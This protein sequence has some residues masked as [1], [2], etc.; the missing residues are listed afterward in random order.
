ME[1]LMRML[2]ILLTCILISCNEVQVS[3]PVGSEEDKTQIKRQNEE[4]KTLEEEVQSFKQEEDQRAAD[5]LLR[6]QQEKEDARIGDTSWLP[7]NRYVF[8]SLNADCNPS[9]AIIFTRLSN[10]IGICAGALIDAETII[11][12]ASCLPQDVIDQV[13]DCKDNVVIK[14]PSRQ[15]LG[16][17]EG[18]KEYDSKQV[19][20]K[21]ILSYSKNE[22][23]SSNF[24]QDTSTNLTADFAIIKLAKPVSRPPFFS[25]PSLTIKA[26]EHYNVIDISRNEGRTGWITVANQKCST[27]KNDSVENGKSNNLLPLDCGG[28]SLAG[29]PIFQTDNSNNSS[30]FGLLQNYSFKKS[31]SF[32]SMGINSGE[33]TFYNL[34]VGLSL[35]CVLDPGSCYNLSL[36]NFVNATVVDDKERQLQIWLGKHDGKAK[37]LVEEPLQDLFEWEFVERVQDSGRLE[38]LFY[39]PGQKNRLGSTID[40]QR[41][42]LGMA[43]PKCFKEMSN[44][45]WLY[46]LGRLKNLTYR[47]NMNV[48]LS[49][50]D[51]KLF[52]YTFDGKYRVSLSTYR[53]KEFKY[54]GY[55]DDKDRE[56]FDL[57]I[58]S[59]NEQAKKEDVMFLTFVDLVP[60]RRMADRIIFTVKVPRCVKDPI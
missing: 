44:I 13:V 2:L 45:H 27:L 24:T 60:N 42:D 48:D 12:S 33:K 38:R 25:H 11:T 49:T 9:S 10:D 58:E 29:S 46:H 36:K 7:Y 23:L 37:Y 43:L 14:F 54:A 6:E 15:S 26:G 51:L 20:C 31:V 19:Q 53:R 22:N 35:S 55:I 8:C 39:L 57:E 28:I 34:K 41:Y 21:R 56:L 4:I 40:Y 1:T 3:I 32:S 18:K 30:I 16:Y 52:N 5:D 17:H 47:Q 50:S 59:N